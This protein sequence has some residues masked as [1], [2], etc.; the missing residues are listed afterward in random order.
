MARMSGG[1]AVAE[2]LRR[3]GV[4]RAFGVP[5]ESFLEVLDALY[6]TPIEFVATRHEGGA[7]FM[8]LAYAKMT[9]EVGVCMGTRAVGASNLAVGI[10]T[11]RQDSL[12]LLALVGQVSRPL[13]GREAFQELDLVGVFSHYCKWAVQ[14][15]DAGRTPELVERPAPW[16]GRCVR[17]WR[18]SG[19]P[20]SR[21]VASS[22]PPG[23]TICSCTSP[24][25]RSCQ[26]SP[27]GDGTIPFPTTTAST[28]ATPAW[29]SPPWCGSG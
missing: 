15:D 28:S 26:S 4:T 18:R 7:A 16:R 12:P 9:G 19:P 8:A 20:S 24:R 3:A 23:L 14:I 6:D 17:C 13:Q 5:G 22:P 29:A 25:R 21:A 10:H 2:V 11:A 1:Q 27:P